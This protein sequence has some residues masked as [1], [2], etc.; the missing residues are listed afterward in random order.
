MTLRDEPGALKTAGL[1]RDCLA[2]VT[3]EGACAACGSTRVA[4]HAELSTLAIAHIDCDAFY[5]SVEK[6][7]R[8]ELRDQAVIV[9]GGTRGV[10]TTACYIARKSGV[11]SAMPMF[12]ARALAPHAIIIKPDMAKYA[13]VSRQVRAIFRATT[14][15]VEPVS[16]DEAYLDL[17]GTEA[18]HGR[19]PAA[20]LAFIANQVEREVKITVSVGLS[21]SKLLAKFASEMDKPRGFGVIGHGDAQAV[22][23]PKPVRALAGVGPKFEQELVAKGF[24]TIGDLQAAGERGLRAALGSRGIWLAARA[25]GRGSSSVEPDRETKSVS[26]ENTFDRDIAGIAALEAEM[27][28]LAERVAERLKKGGISGRVVVLKLKHHDFRL[29]T[30]RR[31]LAQPTQTAETIFATGRRLLAEAAGDGRFRLIGIGV[32]EIADAGLADQ[33]DLFAR[34]GPEATKLEQAMDKLRGR[35]GKDAIGRGRGRGT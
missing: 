26:A 28:P 6:R 27:W 17:S 9:G 19:T 14:P 10:V 32:D 5:A 21:W 12:K 15:L 11:R 30:R 8:P 20:T 31:A 1:C 2:A 25:F 23:A 13:E 35:F 22:L 7:D 29:L 34:A 3:G 4:R 33:P 24:K 16:L 18:L